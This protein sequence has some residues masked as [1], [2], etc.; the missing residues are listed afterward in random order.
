MSM[1]VP[2]V[3]THLTH[4]SFSYLGL[5]WRQDT[6][7]VSGHTEGQIILPEGGSLS[8]GTRVLF[9]GDQGRIRV[10]KGLVKLWPVSL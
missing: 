5:A 10:G 7:R 9:P 2:M 4:S 6:Q 1:T 8:N 3:Q